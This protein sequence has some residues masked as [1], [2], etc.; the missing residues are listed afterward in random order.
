MKLAGIK[1]TTGKFITGYDDKETDTSLSFSKK[2]SKP[3]SLLSSIEDVSAL[4]DIKN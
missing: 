2:K 3:V 4:L 1:Y